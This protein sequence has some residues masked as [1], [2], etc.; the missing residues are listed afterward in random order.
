M[1]ESNKMQARNEQAFIQYFTASMQFG[2][3]S[4]NYESESYKAIVQK[5]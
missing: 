4:L 2:A 3:E 1:A 5:P